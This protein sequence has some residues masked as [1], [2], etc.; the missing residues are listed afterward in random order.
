[1]FYLIGCPDIRSQ[2]QF[3]AETG[4][5]CVTA[6]LDAARAKQALKAIDVE[7][8]R[9]RQNEVQDD[10]DRNEQSLHFAAR[11]IS[12]WH[13]MQ[14]RTNGWLRSRGLRMSCPHTVQTP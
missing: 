2:L 3:F 4:G 9:I 14:V 5:W 1:M 6:G 10:Y 8:D 11:S 12:L 13:S 7:I